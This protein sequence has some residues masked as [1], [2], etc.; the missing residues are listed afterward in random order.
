MNMYVI[1][2]SQRKNGKSDQPG[3]DWLRMGVDTEGDF[4]PV[5]SSDY[6]DGLAYDDP[7][8]EAVTLTFSLLANNL[9]S[10]AALRSSGLA[11]EAA[12]M[13][14]RICDMW[15]LCNDRSP[16][17]P[18]YSTVV[19]WNNPNEGEIIDCLEQELH[20]RVSRAC[21][22]RFTLDV[23]R[24]SPISDECGV[25][26]IPIDERLYRFLK[27][28]KY[29]GDKATA[30]FVE[31]ESLLATEIRDYIYADVSGDAA[32]A[33]FIRGRLEAYYYAV[34]KIWSFHSQSCDSVLLSSGEQDGA[35]EEEKGVE[36]EEEEEEEEEYDVPM[37]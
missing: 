25:I 21:K 29:K 7:A 31:M 4:R 3:C 30:D 24:N 34:K 5:I 12:E 32:K 28:D 35:E 17:R 18:R 22:V 6:L 2:R 8:V 27:G 20:D 37:R 26:R 9:I 15:N 16:R 13:S 10:Y 1:I 36:G 19:T 14:R 11:K 33:A 23:A